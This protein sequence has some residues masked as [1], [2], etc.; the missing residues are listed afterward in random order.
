MNS[1]GEHKV[2][3]SPVSQPSQQP[4]DAARS[5]VLK[6]SCAALLGMR[7]VHL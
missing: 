3:L 2:C 1:A 5:V 6:L 7:K 4:P